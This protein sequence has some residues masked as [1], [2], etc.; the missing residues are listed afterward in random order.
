MRTR[1]VLTTISLFLAWILPT[2]IF[3]QDVVNLTSEILIGKNQ[4][5]THNT[6]II[7][8]TNTAQI[9]RY[10]SDFRVDEDGWTGGFADYP[11]DVVPE[12]WQMEFGYESLPASLNVD[13]NG[14]M[15]QGNNHSDDLFMYAKRPY[16]GLMPNTTYRVFFRVTLA[17]NAPTGSVG[18]GGSPGDSVYVKA[19]VSVVEP[20]T[21]VVAGD[22]HWRMNIDKGNQASSGRDAVTI[23]TIGVELPGVG[24]GLLYKMKILENSLPLYVTTDDQGTVWLLVGT[25]SGF[26]ALT[27]VYFADIAVEF[28]PVASVHYQSDF[29]VDEDGWA[30]GF[31]DYPLDV[32]PKD[33]NMEF[34]YEPLPASLNVN[35]NCLMLQGNN[36]S[37]DLFMYAKRPFSGLCPNTTYQVKFDVILASNAATGTVGVGGSPGDSVYV[38]AGVSVV[39]PDAV[40]VEDDDHWRM[41]IDK[42]NQ[43]SSGEDAIT[44][45][46]IGVKLPG[47]GGGPLYKFKT[48][49]NS[50]PLFV[51]TDDHG[52]VWLLVGTDSGFEALT[53]VYFTDIAVEFTPLSSIRYRSDFSVDEDGWTGGFADYPLDVL[54]DDWNM[55]FG[56]EPLPASLNMDDSGL[57]LQGSNHSDDLFMYSKRLFSDLCPNTTYRVK[58]DV[59]LASNAATGIVGV[60]G[61]P[62]DSVYVKAGASVVEP[63]AVVIEGDDHWRMNIDKGNQASSGEDAI[64]IGTIGVKLPGVGG[65]PL[66]KMKTLDNFQD[67]LFVTSDDLGTVWLLVGTDSGFEA[68]TRIYI[69][70][71]TVEF[72]PVPEEN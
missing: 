31:A 69:V 16:D 38:K 51:T 42:G 67:P 2:V 48:L 50:L 21:V 8:D 3:A 64:T 23:G 22:D 63:Y 40:V 61:S 25:D 13:A 43:A 70:D 55:Q 47:L 39:E 34:G 60:G 6:E 37:D 54:P 52:T 11:L 9:I 58:F 33:W 59:T 56:Y 24:G 44:I 5:T 28:A 49:E 4:K 27:R 35:A 36:H 72:T 1:S 71:I 19:G 20:L 57:M 62:G 18:V 12:D 10:Q 66:Y 29:S 7:D 45:G 65:G 26:E 17:S 53:R 68:L 46:T 14:L 15:L 41:N 32:L 30:G